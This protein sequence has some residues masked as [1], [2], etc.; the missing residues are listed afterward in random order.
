MRINL[1]EIQFFLHE[2]VFKQFVTKVCL[3]RVHSRYQVPSA[4]T[5]WGRVMHICIGNLTIIGS[6][7]GM[8][9]VQCQAIISTN[10][11]ILSVGPLG[12][13][14]NE[15]LIRTQTFSFNKMQLKMSSE[16][17]QPFSIGLN[18]LNNASKPLNFNICIGFYFKSCNDHTITLPKHIILK[19]KVLKSSEFHWPTNPFSNLISLHNAGSGCSL[20]V[21]VC[22]INSPEWQDK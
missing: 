19:Q 22:N 20:L 10:A 5:H 9:P 21:P 15:I 8:S 3:K 4:L 12:T 11:G 7:N 6:D 18:V 14:F 1:S 2:K 13:N 16:T 17:W